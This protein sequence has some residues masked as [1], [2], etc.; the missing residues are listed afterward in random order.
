[1]F[2]MIQVNVWW[3]QS[4]ALPKHW[5]EYGEAME[6]VI[7]VQRRSAHHRLKFE[8]AK[9]SSSD[10]CRSILLSAISRKFINLPSKS[11]M[12]DGNG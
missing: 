10:S 11:Y 8:S 5:D 4:Q 6:N 7:I 12:Q 3:E 2:A 1:M 9:N